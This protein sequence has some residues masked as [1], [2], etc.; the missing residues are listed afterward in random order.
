MQQNKWPTKALELRIEKSEHSQSIQRLGYWLS[1]RMP[2]STLGLWTILQSSKV[3]HYFEIDSMQQNKRP[4]SGSESGIDTWSPPVG[5]AVRNCCSHP[6]GPG[7]TPGLEHILEASSVCWRKKIR[8]CGPHPLVPGSTPCFWK[9]CSRTGSVTSLKWIPTLNSK[10]PTRATSLRITVC[11]VLVGLVARLCDS[12][13]QV[14]GSTPGLWKVLDRSSVSRYIEL[15]FADFTLK[16][17]P[18]VSGSTPGVGK[19]LPASKAFY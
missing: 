3:F 2:E 1:P 4:T 12:Q 9:K 15:R 7:S 10:R 14:P 19:I 18:Q 11:T 8:I 5:L 16:S 17:H 6:Q 13:P